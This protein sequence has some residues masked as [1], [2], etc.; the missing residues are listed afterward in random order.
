MCTALLAAGAHIDARNIAGETALF[1][2]VEAGRADVVRCLLLHGTDVGV[3]EKNTGLT[4]LQ[5]A[6]TF[7]REDVVA[8]LLEKAEE[9]VG[10][11]GGGEGDHESYAP[12]KEATSAGFLD[13][14]RRMLDAGINPFALNQEGAEMG[15][16]SAAAVAVISCWRNGGMGFVEF[17]DEEDEEDEE[18]EDEEE[19]EEEDDDEEEEE[20]DDEE[21]E[22]QEYVNGGGLGVR[23]VGN[24]NKRRRIEGAE[25][26]RRGERWQSLGRKRRQVEPESIRWSRRARR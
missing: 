3:V 16:C 9:Q 1:V 2:A 26:D 18:E 6:V 25:E 19:E 23:F 14:V 17:D 12:L 8:C 20:D 15:S 13:A 11:Y 7:G 21:E 24:T 4:A 5:K 10:V 22:E